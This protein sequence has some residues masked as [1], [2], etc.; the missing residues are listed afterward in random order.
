M[1][2]ENIIALLQ[3]IV[4]TAVSFVS[5]VMSVNFEKWIPSST[6]RL[7][8][9]TRRSETVIAEMESSRN[10]LNRFSFGLIANAINRKISH[11]SFHR[12]LGPNGGS[13]V[14]SGWGLITPGCLFASVFL[15]GPSA[16]AFWRFYFLL[17]FSENPKDHLPNT[18]LLLFALGLAGVC[19]SLLLAIP[20]SRHFIVNLGI[21]EFVDPFF[22]RTFAVKGIKGTL[23]FCRRL[24]ER[25]YAT[26][27]ARR[28]RDIALACF[29]S[30]FF[31]PILLLIGQRWGQQY[32]W[33]VVAEHI[34]YAVLILLVVT[35]AGAEISFRFMLSREKVKA[36]REC[37]WIKV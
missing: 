22:N 25:I 18:T 6:Y 1:I 32:Y 28:C 26:K 5:V 12:M 20:L 23:I 4:S 8:R 3:L 19:L 34:F 15:A 11:K 24:L 13:P 31:I 17:L 27:T 33:A 2:T 14:F 7:W 29:I 36:R 10:D 30:V 37:T 9:L 21:N 35:M 16:Y